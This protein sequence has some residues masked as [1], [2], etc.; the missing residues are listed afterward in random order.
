MPAITVKNIPDE[1]YNQLKFAA[2]QHR[3]SVNSELI[4]CLE[5]VLSPQKL[6]ANDHIAAAQRIRQRFDDFEVTQD[7]LQNAKNMDRA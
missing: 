5:K 3:R 1:L 6:T 4:S 7:D 2:K